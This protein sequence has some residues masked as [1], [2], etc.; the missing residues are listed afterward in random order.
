[1]QNVYV[2]TI[3]MPSGMYWYT[4]VF[5]TRGTVFD[6][7]ARET[8]AG[9]LWS[10]SRLYSTNNRYI[11]LPMHCWHNNTV[12]RMA[13]YVYTQHIM[14]NGKFQQ[15]RVSK[16]D[17]Q[18]PLGRHR[19]ACFSVVSSNHVTTTS[20]GEKQLLKQQSVVIFQRTVVYVVLIT[21]KQSDTNLTLNRFLYGRREIKGQS[22]LQHACMHPELP[23]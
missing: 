4:S 14:F 1:M 13:M 22:T 5:Q 7:S 10:L 23:P 15:A 6:L 3:C 11:P 18:L 2:I 9:R 17:V 12:C 8:T 21:G 16:S 20:N 19:G